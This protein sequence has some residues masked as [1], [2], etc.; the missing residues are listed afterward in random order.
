MA[1]SD[2]P[3]EGSILDIYMKSLQFS[4]YQFLNVSLQRYNM[5]CG[6]QNDGL[7]RCPHL[8]PRTCEYVR[9]QDKGELRLNAIKVANQLT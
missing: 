2:L 9:L 3:R 8:T 7:Q 1:I 6:Q 5:P 4:I